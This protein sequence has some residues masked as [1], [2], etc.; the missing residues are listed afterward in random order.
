MSCPLDGCRRRR[1]QNTNELQEEGTRLSGRSG[2][3]DAS[4]TA[5]AAGGWPQRPGGRSFFVEVTAGRGEHTQLA[6]RTA[7]RGTYG[8]ALR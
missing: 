7:E 8:I 2:A 4:V 3:G 6:T 5:G 1:A